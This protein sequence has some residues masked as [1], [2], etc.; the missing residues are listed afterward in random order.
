MHKVYLFLLKY[1]LPLSVLL[2]L[3]LIKNK[4]MVKDEMTACDISSHILQSPVLAANQ[5]EAEIRTE[6]PSTC[7]QL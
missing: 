3:S 1:N 4:R 2:S 7:K 6:E 5:C